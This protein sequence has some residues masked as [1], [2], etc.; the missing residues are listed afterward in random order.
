LALR[1]EPGAI[2]TPQPAKNIHAIL[3]AKHARFDA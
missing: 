2:S 1:I 3:L